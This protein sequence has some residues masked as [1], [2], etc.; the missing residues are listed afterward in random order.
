M[1]NIEALKNLMRRVPGKA[2]LAAGGLL[3][4]AFWLQQHDA[5]IRQQARLQQLRIETSAQVAA[6]RSQAAQDVKQANVENAKAIAEIERR[7]Q[8][9]EQQSRQLAAELEGVRRQAQ[10]QAG[11]VAT[12]PISEIVTRV[13]AQLGLNAGDVLPPHS[14]ADAQDK[15]Q[16]T[17]DELQNP[18]GPSAQAGVGNRSVC[19]LCGPKALTQRARR[20]SVS[21]VLD[22]FNPRSAQ[23]RRGKE[24]MNYGL[25]QPGAE[26]VEG[27]EQT[28]HPDAGASTLSPRSLCDN[29]GEGTSNEEG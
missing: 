20:P 5:R 15:L 12:L 25:S 26:S 11:Q 10:I 8:Q 13:A 2:W 7:R 23:R 1:A 19:D 9:A 21:S 29:R 16:I 4:G 28:P 3:V 17:N 18:G 22:L 27:G 6:L 14:S 24:I